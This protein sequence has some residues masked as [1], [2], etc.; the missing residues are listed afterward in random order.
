MRLNLSGALGSPK[1]KHKMVGW[2]GLEPTTNSLKGYCST[3][4][5]PTRGRGGRNRTDDKRFAISRLTTWLPRVSNP[6][7]LLFC[8]ST[9]RIYHTMGEA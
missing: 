1:V 5:L 2:V 3:I 4:E 8:G 9:N 7:Q 6:N